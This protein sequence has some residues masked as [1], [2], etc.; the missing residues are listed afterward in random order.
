MLGVRASLRGIGMRITKL[1]S[2]LRRQSECH[3]G[4]TEQIV[5]VGKLSSSIMSRQHVLLFMKDA[6]SLHGVYR[7]CSEEKTT[8]QRRSGL[9]SNKS[10]HF[11]LHDFVLLLGIDLL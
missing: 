11:F 2:S 1:G 3:H 8:A 6:T 10:D 4:A 9:D 7:G 5:E